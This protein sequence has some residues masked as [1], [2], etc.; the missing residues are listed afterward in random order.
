MSLPVR[1]FLVY[2]GEISLKKANRPHFEGRLIRNIQRAARGLGVGA[3]KRLYGRLQ[4][5]QLAS[6]DPEALVARLQRVYGITH[7]D[8]VERL[9]LDLDAVEE[10]ALREVEPGGFASFAVRC[11][12][13]NK[14]FPLGSQEICVRLGN[15]IGVKSQA[16]VDLA[17]PERV[18][19]VLVLNREIY[20][21][22]RQYP[23]P[24]GLPVGVGGRVLSLLSGGIDS[25]V[26][27]ELMMKRGIHPVFVHFHSSPFTDRSSVDKTIELAE[28]ICRDRIG[29]TLH[30]MSLGAL[31][32]QIVAEAPAAYR[33]ILYRRYMLRLAERM[34]RKRKCL[35]LVTG[36]NLGQVSSQTL[37]N[38]YVLDRTTTMP[39]Y[40][41]LLTY[42]KQ[43]II[44]LARVMGTF[45]I[46]IEPHADC[47]S[48]LM[49]RRPVTHA[50]LRDVCEIEEK[51]ALNERLLEVYE[52][53]EVVDIGKR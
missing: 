51:L 6:Q 33:V 46:S 29:T 43:E 32:K 37:Q 40:R 48:F 44:D 7:I 24:R 1:T 36:E 31:Q 52:A 26:A 30:I 42:D 38:Q 35:G 25:P 23:G 49:P 16:R 5:D 27:A 14:Q 15:A 45:E 11:K 21:Y 18:F 12:R 47:C 2:Y 3:V 19:H 22:H 17:E 20:L 10:A 41:P 34:A 50:R 28:I 53:A 39:I 8:P 13:I 4:V 9:P